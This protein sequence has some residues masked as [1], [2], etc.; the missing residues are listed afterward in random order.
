M[1]IEIAL[2]TH[3]IPHTWPEEVTKEVAGLGEQVPEKAKEGRI[4]LR[5]LP[6]VTIDGEDARDYDA[7]FCEAKRGGGWRLWLRHRGRI[8]LCEARHGAGCR[9]LSARQLRLFP[10]VRGAHAAGG[11][12]QRPLLPEPAG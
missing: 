4:D 8:R 5:A 10:R 12:L 2:R 7:V 11:A 9:S 1:E 3:G 6:L